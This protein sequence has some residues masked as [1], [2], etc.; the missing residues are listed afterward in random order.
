[1]NKMNKKVEINESCIR[2]LFNL[3]EQQIV[4]LLKIKTHKCGVRKSYTPLDI[5]V[6]L[7]IEYEFNE[8]GEICNKKYDGVRKFFQELRNKL[9][10]KSDDSILM[11]YVEKHI[12]KITQENENNRSK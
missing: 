1:M 3:N 10:V 2:F 9:E 4:D 8:K 6:S 7:H 12:E 11:D 5:A